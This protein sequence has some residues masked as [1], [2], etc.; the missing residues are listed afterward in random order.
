MS[1]VLPAVMGSCWSL[2]GRMVN[3]W[4]GVRSV[5][6]G[7]ALVTIV[8][9]MA[10]PLGQVMSSGS[11]PRL[12]ALAKSQL[13]FQPSTGVRLR[14]RGRSLRV[15]E[16]FI[17]AF[18]SPLRASHPFSLS[19][20]DGP[21]EWHRNNIARCAVQFADVG[22]RS[23][24][25]IQ[26]SSMSFRPSTARSEISSAISDDGDSRPQSAINPLS[27][28]EP[29]E[30]E[31]Q[32]YTHLRGIYNPNRTT[33]S[34]PPGAPSSTTGSSRTHT[35][36]SQTART[37]IP[38]LTAHGFFR[39]L[40]SQRLQAQRL[41]RPNTSSTAPPPI[42]DTPEEPNEESV[43]QE[44]PAATPGHHRPAPSIGTE[45]SEPETRGTSFETRLHN[46]ATP[47]PP[48]N[49]HTQTPQPQESA[50]SAPLSLAPESTPSRQYEPPQK[51]PLSFRSA[52]SLGS[53]RQ[54][55]HQPLSSTVTSPR[56]NV[57]V[58]PATSTRHNLGKNYEYFEGNTLFWM[59]GR[60]QNSRDKPI[61]VATGIMLVL[62]AVLFFVY[63]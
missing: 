61:N 43:Q 25:R 55:G 11:Q 33:R 21:R 38:S 60:L 22:P 44:S 57:V 35:P 53:K 49:G 16:V 36:T 32:G 39:P 48:V 42:A 58:P 45:Y 20:H 5:F 2:N 6:A 10:A 24:K 34:P 26:L 18:S 13:L 7:L 56:Y 30:P 29:V 62:P 28:P 31:P 14:S 50:K 3:A 15:T 12:A 4:S 59:G 37:H 46:N 54:P 47:R 41:R 51:S 23:Q 40:S 63:S 9:G 52:F 17:Y 1:V 19:T 27:S 8:I